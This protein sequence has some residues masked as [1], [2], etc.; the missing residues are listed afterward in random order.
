MEYS[1]I[2]SIIAIFI[3]FSTAFLTIYLRYFRVVRHISIIGVDGWVK[4]KIL[5]ITVV[6]NNRGNQPT[7][8][9]SCTLFLH[10]TGEDDVKKPARVPPFSLLGGEQKAVTIQYALLK[11]EN[12]VNNSLRDKDIDIITLFTDTKG[13]LYNSR[14]SVGIMIDNSTKGKTILAPWVIHNVEIL[15]ENRLYK[16]KTTPDIAQASARLP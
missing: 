8:F 14:Y 2:I 4:D 10:G 16:K 15:L 12:S 9:A 11:D 13:I 7:T 1:L 5:N 3:S 6:Y